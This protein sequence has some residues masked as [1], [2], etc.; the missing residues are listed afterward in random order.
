MNSSRRL[1]FPALVAAGVLW[2]TTVPLSKLALAWLG[3]AWLTAARFGLA[4]AVLMMVVGGSRLRGAWSPA[5]AISGAVGYGGSVLLQNMGVQR[6][7]V[8]HAAL[9]IG[10]TPVLVAIMAA[11]LGHSIARPLA[12]LG[13]ALSLAGVTVIAGRQGSG[14]TLGGDGMVLAAQLISAAFTVSQ[15]R[16]LRG[17]DPVAV[18]ALQLGVAGLAMLPVALITEATPGRPANSAALVAV[19]ALVLAGTVLPTTLFATAQAKVS[20]DVA[21]AFV[22]LEPL[23]GAAAGTALFGDPLGPVQLAGGG[24]IAVGIALSSLQ[25]IRSGRRRQ[26]PALPVTAEAAPARAAATSTPAGIASAR[27]RV[28]LTPAHAPPLPRPAWSARIQGRARLSPGGTAESTRLRRHRMRPTSRR[29]RDSSPGRR[30]RRGNPIWPRHA[31]GQ[32]LVNDRRTRPLHVTA[33]WPYRR[34][35]AVAADWLPL[36]VP[37]QDLAACIDIRAR[38][39]DRRH[40]IIRHHAGW[41]RHR[42]PRLAAELSEWSSIV[43]HDLTSSWIPARTP[44]HGTALG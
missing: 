24:A 6:T 35:V 7:S 2:G 31:R 41:P 4:A 32:I 42:D 21:G 14:S 20:A 40:G 18:T 39:V 16:L 8:T 15:A 34:G 10:A 33:E 12:W 25:L 29:A 43:G 36:R 19:I 44:D 9:L 17:R 13:F 3:P 27:A 22:N 11:I 30:P 5:V 26:H 38:E 28:V 1:V 23:V 37:A